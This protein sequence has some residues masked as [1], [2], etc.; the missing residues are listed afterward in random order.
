MSSAGGADRRIRVDRPATAG[1]DLEVEVGRAA[2]VARVADVADHSS[3]SDVAGTDVGVRVEVGA[4]V[5]VA[6]VAVEVPREANDPVAAVRP[7]A[8]HGSEI[9]RAAGGDGGWQYG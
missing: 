5:V 1:V 3:R 7:G 2:C 9:G 8:A 6:V 4:V